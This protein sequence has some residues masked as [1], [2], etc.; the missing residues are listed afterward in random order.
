MGCAEH[1]IDRRRMAFEDRR[2][3]VDDVLD[4]LVGR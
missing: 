3:C 2:Q 4:A 1:D